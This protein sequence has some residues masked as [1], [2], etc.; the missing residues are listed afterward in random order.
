MRNFPVTLLR[1]SLSESGMMPGVLDIL[2]YKFGGSD[3]V[4]ALT[5]SYFDD[6]FI[7]RQNIQNAG[8]A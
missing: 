1:L 8:F 2:L 6:N 3:F 4:A 5:V 7:R